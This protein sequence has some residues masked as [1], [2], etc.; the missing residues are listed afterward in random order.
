MI[1][2]VY[3]CQGFI[4]WDKTVLV[5]QD[6]F[7][8]KTVIWFFVLIIVAVVFI[9]IYCFF[10]HEVGL[11]VLLSSKLTSACFSF[12]SYSVDLLLIS[13]LFPFD[14]SLISMWYSNIQLTHTTW[15]L[16]VFC[17]WYWIWLGV[18]W[19]WWW[20]C[21]IFQDARG[22]VVW[23]GVVRQDEHGDVLMHTMGG[24]VKV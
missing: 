2:C 7:K 13:K 18:S 9:C 16:T 19:W 6:A 12:P 23:F 8:K 22:K 4:I 17:L 10:N 11:F 21:W 1:L 14:Y 15:L 24:G 5:L 3:V 20:C